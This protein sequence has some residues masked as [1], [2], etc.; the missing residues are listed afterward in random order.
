MLRPIVLRP[1][2]FGKKKHP[3]GAYDHILITVRQ[4]QA[5]WC[6]AL[7]LTRGRVC[8]LLFLLVLA[9]AAI[10]GSGSLGTRDHILLSQIRG[11]PFR[12]LLSLSVLTCPP[13]VTSRRTEAPTVLSFYCRDRNFGNEFTEPSNGHVGH[14]TIRLSKYQTW[15]S[16]SD[17]NK[18]LFQHLR[19][20]TL[21]SLQLHVRTYS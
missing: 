10:L 19:N 8:R 9:R 4:L 17:H 14:N 6:E 12:R 13:T 11:F 2:Y 1:L 20:V 7:S 18:T 3:Y 5:C 16:K 21:L 15:V